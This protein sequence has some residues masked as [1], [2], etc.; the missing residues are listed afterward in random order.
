MRYRRKKSERGIA[1]VTT[2]G[3]LA[4]VSLL[5]ASAVVLSQYAEKDSYTFS[6]FTRSTYIA[7]GVANRLYWLI[8]NDRQ[9]YPQR[10]IDVSDDA[11]QEEEERYLADGT[12]RIFENYYGEKIKYEI[13]DAV[14]GMDVSGS[15]PQRDLIA[16]MGNLE[17][18]SV[19]RQKLEMIG[20]RLQDY[21]D[22]TQIARNGTE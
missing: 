12:P 22:G 11:L 20:N 3:I 10:N 15:M 21:V 14:G 5:A 16:L 1:L 13:R 19:E 4:A 9:K 17:K 6:S 18:D 7:E 2:L 8:L